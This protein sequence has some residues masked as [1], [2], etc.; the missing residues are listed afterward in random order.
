MLFVDPPK[1]LAVE[2]R[3]GKAFLSWKKVAEPAAGYNVYRG[4][5][6]LPWKVKYRKIT[7]APVE[8]TEFTDPTP[9]PADGKKMAFYYV[10]PQ[11]KNGFEGPASCKVRTQ[12]PL[13]GGLV[14]SVLADRTVELAW[15]KSPAED[16]VGYHVYASA[17]APKKRLVTNCIE[18]DSGWKRLTEKPVRDPTFLDERKL[19]KTEGVFGHEVRN[20][21]VR[22]VNSLGVESGPSERGFTLTGSVPHARAKMNADGSATITW[23]RSPEKGVIGYVVYRLDEVR[24]S[25]VVRLNAHPVKDLKFVDRAETPRAER[26]RYYVVAVDALGQEGM[27]SSGAWLFGRP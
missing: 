22:A 15:K 2:I 19:A 3:R 25:A 14:V 12:P 10:K 9:P 27:P 1:G 21:Q 4:E 23:E 5:G 24:N 26:R 8:R 6:T 18:T 13:P 11:A 17:I 16:V 20:Y 7:D